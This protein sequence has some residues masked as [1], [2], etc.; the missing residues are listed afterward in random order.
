MLKLIGG[1][2]AN[3][4]RLQYPNTNRKKPSSQC[5]KLIIIS[6]KRYKK[7]SIWV[8]RCIQIVKIFKLKYCAEKIKLHYEK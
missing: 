2:N 6:Q 7:F 5:D 3:E 8:P 4:A 1:N